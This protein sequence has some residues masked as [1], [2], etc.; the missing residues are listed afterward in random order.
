VDRCF[1]LT[2]GGALQYRIVYSPACE[3]H[4]LNLSK[5][6]RMIVL[7]AVELQLGHQ[8]DLETRNRKL[9]R[10]NP[11]APWELRIGDLRVFYDIEEEPEAVVHVRAVGIKEHGTLKIGGE[12]F[13][14]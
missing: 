4:L 2:L 6:D 7:S 9:L 11:I 5:R 13:F 12:E 8:P 3:E 10:S 14:L 1:A